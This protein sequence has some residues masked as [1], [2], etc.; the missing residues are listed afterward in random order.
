MLLLSKEIE[1]FLKHV[2]TISA[3]WTS[4]GDHFG[5]IGCPGVHLVTKV[6]I[7][8]DFRE[9]Y[10]LH[11]ELLLAPLEVTFFILV[12]QGHKFRDL[13]EVIVARSLF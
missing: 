6:W 13:F 8:V 11:F 1:G 12:V 7:W 5:V 3:H 4:R 9:N 10:Y 2:S